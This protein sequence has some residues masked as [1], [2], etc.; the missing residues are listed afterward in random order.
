MSASARTAA[1]AAFALLMMVGAFIIARS[2][3][4]APDLARGWLVAFAICSAV[5]IGA[6]VLSLIHRLTGGDWGVA[7]QPTLGGLAAVT[8]FVALAFAPIAVAAAAIYPWVGDAGA[9]PANVARDYLNLPFFLLRAVVALGGWALLGVLAALDSVNRLTA[10]L[11]LAFYGF[12][13]SFAAVDWFLSIEPRYTATAFAAMI[14]IEHL[15]A[16]LA[17]AA[18][19]GGPSLRGRAAGDVGGLLIATLLGVVYMQLMIFVIAWYGDQP[20]QAAWWVERQTPGWVVTILA[21]LAFGGL[22]PISMLMV[23]KVRR[24]RSGLRLAGLLV[25]I[26]TALHFCWLLAPAYTSAKHV[27]AF[28]VVS[29]LALTLLLMSVGA[30][31]SSRLEAAHAVR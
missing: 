23:E 1:V 5:P 3:D 15:G 4:I 30:A 20:A 9:A 22:I 21:A 31:L 24:S 16:A 7:V 11:G 14:A 29:V 10:A 8:P 17:F 27:V 18:L 6:M 13:I 2:F 19:I 26:G 28:A 25:L 12:T